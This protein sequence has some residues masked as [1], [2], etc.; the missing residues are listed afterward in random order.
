M[1]ARY[2]PDRVHHDHDGEPPD[3]AYTGKSHGT[4]LAQIHGHHAAPGEN[5]EICTKYLRNDLQKKKKTAKKKRTN[6]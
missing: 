3:G 5:Q 6:D 2:V 1:G 4:P